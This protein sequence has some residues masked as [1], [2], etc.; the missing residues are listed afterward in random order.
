MHEDRI[1]PNLVVESSDSVQTLRIE[2]PER[3]NALSSSMVDSLID[4]ARAVSSDRTLRACIITGTGR[5]FVAGADI[6]EYDGVSQSGFDAYQRKSRRMF[7][8]IA[9]ISHPT[10]AAVN[11]YALGGGLELALSCDFMIVSETATLGLPEV[12]LGLL[13]G[14]GGTQRLARLVGHARAKELIMTGRSMTAAEAVGYGAA[15]DSVPAEI[16]IERSGQL[17]ALLARNAP[18]AVAE[19]K[20]VVADGTDCSLAAG[21][22]LEQRALS[23]LFATDDATEGIQAFIEKRDAHFSG[24]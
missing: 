24:A 18:I 2:R 6:S 21:L 22:T 23:G 3:L 14:G 1:H 7:D 20:R 4:W 9:E 11:G 13:P 19:I 8:S 15:L 10:I 12:K 16:L 17:A 5:A